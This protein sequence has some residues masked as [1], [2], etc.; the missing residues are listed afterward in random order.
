MH[1]YYCVPSPRHPASQRHST[2]YC[3]DIGPAIHDVTA[4]QTNYE[5]MVKMEEVNDATILHNL[6]HRFKIGDIYT[7][8]GPILVSINPFEWKTSDEYYSEDWVRTF[9]EAV[10]IDDVR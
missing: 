1:A 7:K 10:D 4:L 6:R 3:S 5:D 8:I 9:V 2:I